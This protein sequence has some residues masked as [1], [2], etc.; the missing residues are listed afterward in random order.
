MITSNPARILKL[1]KKGEIR[2][3]HDADLVLLEKESLAI[4]TVI[5]KGRVMV[6]EGVPLVKGTFEQ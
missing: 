4:D 1:K 6:E 5:A 3:Q 2:E